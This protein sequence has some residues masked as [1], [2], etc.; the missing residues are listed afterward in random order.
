MMSWPISTEQIMT[1]TLMQRTSVSLHGSYKLHTLTKY[2]EVTADDK[3]TVYL[4][5]A[6]N[7]R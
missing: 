3:G 1:M 5:F 7:T 2:G 4:D 6:R